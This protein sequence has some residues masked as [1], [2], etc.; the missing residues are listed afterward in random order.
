MNKIALIIIMMFSGMASAQ[1]VDVDPIGAVDLAK[2][3]GNIR[4]GYLFGHNS[5]ASAYVPII[6]FKG[7]KSGV[8]YINLNGGLGY[9]QDTRK[10]KPIGIVG[11][12]IDSML[13]KLGR[14]VPNIAVAKFP[15]LE[16]G[17]TAMI[18]FSEA[19]PLKNV[20]FMFSI[21][22]KLGGN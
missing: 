2:F 18:D 4:T 17:P 16:I 10:G 21:A 22:Y 13:S 19:H 1:S 20:K 6:S 8:E 15:P 9:D 12:R 11:F 7:P 14:T 5:M 3:F